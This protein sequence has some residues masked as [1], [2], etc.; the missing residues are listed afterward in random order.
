MISVRLDPEKCRGCTICIKRCPTEAIRVR[1]GR[2]KIIKERC[3]DCGNCVRSCYY[4]AKVAVADPLSRVSDFTH[5]IALPAPS[6]F[7]Q[8]KNLEDPGV[9][10]RALL[11]MGFSEVF[12]PALAAEMISALTA[13]KLGKNAPKPLV[14]SACPAVLR[15]ITQRFPNMIPHV[16]DLISP[17]ELAAKLA[18]GRAVARTGLRP[19]DV[20]VFFISP[21]PAKVTESHQPSRLDAPVIDYA[22]SMSEVYFKLL[23][24][25]K[26]SQAMPRAARDGLRWAFSGGESRLLGDARCAFVGGLDNVIGM[27]E[28][29]DGEEDSELD[30]LELGACPGG[31]VGGCLTVENPFTAAARLRRLAAAAASGPDA[32]ASPVEVFSQD[33]IAEQAKPARE[34]IYTPTT[35]LDRD[36][37]RA[38]Q[39]LRQVEE[40]KERLPGLDCG[41]CGAPGC[42]ALA[43]DVILGW[44]EESDCIFNVRDGVEYAANDGIYLPPPFRR[45]KD[46]E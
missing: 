13:S 42:H 16:L 24:L 39:K 32:G 18:R 20:G 29:L 2:A 21:C 45:R 22:V 14:S 31:C 10:L 17:A 44:A 8:F 28:T 30:Y 38:M 43:E 3:I 37:G 9:V 5:S 23:P 36:V 7:G 35:I 25:M 1:S 41:S 34:L 46:D 4:H 15:L 11:G 19:R 12:E 33:F 6:L 26:R 40:L 27:L